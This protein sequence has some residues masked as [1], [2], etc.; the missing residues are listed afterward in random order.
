MKNKHYENQW[1]KSTN[2]FSSADMLQIFCLFMLQSIFPSALNIENSSFHARHMQILSH[3]AFIDQHILTTSWKRN[4]IYYNHSISMNGF[5]NKL[6][7]LWIALKWNLCHSLYSFTDLPHRKK[8]K[9]I[10]NR[11]KLHGLCVRCSL[12]ISHVWTLATFCIVHSKCRA[13]NIY[14]WCKEQ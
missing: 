1:T 11:I 6:I 13:L 3:F 9:N 4:V 5:L 8:K 14:I 7:P 2:Y 12:F 10:E